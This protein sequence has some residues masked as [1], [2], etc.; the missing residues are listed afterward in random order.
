MNAN[1]SNCFEQLSFARRFASI[2][3][4]NSSTE[5]PLYLYTMCSFMALYKF[6]FKFNFKIPANKI[7]M[8]KIDS[9]AWHVER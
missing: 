2:I 8:W 4:S 1:I 6:V 7:M 5:A 9:V 3:S